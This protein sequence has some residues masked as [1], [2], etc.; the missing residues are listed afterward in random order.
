MIAESRA[1]DPTLYRLRARRSDEHG[2]EWDAIRALSPRRRRQLVGAGFLGC[3]FGYA[4]DQLAD[5]VNHDTNGDLS[6][7]D[8]VAVWLAAVEQYVA[9]SR[10]EARRRRERRLAGR[11]GL[12][13]HEYRA[14]LYADRGSASV[15]HYARA[16]GWR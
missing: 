1:I 9:E 4:P 12:T 15:H 11:Y 6:T 7:C 8:A 5:E 3:R 13:W 16:V 2:G 10:R 14:G